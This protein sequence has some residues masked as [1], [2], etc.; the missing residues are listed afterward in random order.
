MDLST[1]FLK[2]PC[3]Q[4]VWDFA[5]VCS[6]DRQHMPHLQFARNASSQIPPINHNLH[7]KKIPG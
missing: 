6:V 3:I 4:V 5:K 2:I 7:F 1:V